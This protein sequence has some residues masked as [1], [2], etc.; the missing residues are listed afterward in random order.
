[1]GDVGFSLITSLPQILISVDELGHFNTLLP[2]SY[3][4]SCNE[5]YLEPSSQLLIILLLSLLAVHLII[6]VSNFCRIVLDGDGVEG[7]RRPYHWVNGHVSQ[8]HIST[9]TIGQRIKTLLQLEL[10][11]AD[12]I[13]DAA[14]QTEGQDA[15]E[16]DSAGKDVY[17]WVERVIRV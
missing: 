6:I 9:S 5:L 10:A 15:E 8:V 17:E 11:F 16:A 3:L 13:S 4:F 2:H 12:A 1:M 7:S 14:R